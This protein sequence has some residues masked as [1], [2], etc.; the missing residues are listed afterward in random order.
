MSIITLFLVMMFLAWNYLCSVLVWNN[1][2][3][4]DVSYERLVALLT[5]YK[6]P[7]YKLNDGPCLQYSIHLHNYMESNGIKCGIVLV[8]RGMEC[9]E[10]HA[11]N[12]FKTT[13]KGE[14]YLDLTFNGSIIT[15]DDVLETRNPTTKIISIEKYDIT[16]LPITLFNPFIPIGEN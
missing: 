16:L 14:L 6:K 10:Y 3:A 7:D 15:W 2:Q 1:P 12:Y 5:D 13:D 4:I 11:F 8:K 9:Y